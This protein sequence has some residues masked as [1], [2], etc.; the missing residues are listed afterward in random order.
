MCFL[1]IHVLLLQDSMRQA[2]NS[3]SKLL[4]RI[5]AKI[6][7]EDHIIFRGKFSHENRKK[8]VVIIRV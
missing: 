7:H 6:S 8:N 2:N 1:I 4:T 5:G 3:F